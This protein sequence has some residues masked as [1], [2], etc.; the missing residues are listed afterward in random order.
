MASERSREY[1]IAFTMVV[2]SS[3]VGTV[4]G[5]EFLERGL[6][7]L[8][9]CCKVQFVSCPVVLHCKTRYNL[10]RQTT[11][12]ISNFISMCVSF[13]FCHACFSYF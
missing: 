2:I 12:H 11:S 9:E 13:H 4:A 5:A 3:G 1:E 6:E 7:D 8:G 10:Q